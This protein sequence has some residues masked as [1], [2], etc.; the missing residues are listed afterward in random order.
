MSD[1]QEACYWD[2]TDDIMHGH[3]DL[4]SVSAGSFS[5]LL[6]FC[7]HVMPCPQEMLSPFRLANET[8]LLI[9]IFSHNEGV[10]I[11]GCKCVQVTECAA[12]ATFL[13]AP[14]SWP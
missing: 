2:V 13:V 8:G 4:P 14:P 12:A 11:F 3:C 1:R 7:R 9:K 10:G 6:L 5:R